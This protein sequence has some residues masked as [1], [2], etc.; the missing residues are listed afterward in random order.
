MKKQG[1]IKLI[2]NKDEDRHL[3]K[4]SG[5]ILLQENDYEITSK[6]VSVR[7]KKVLPLLI[8]SQQTVY[9]TNRCISQ[10][11]RIISDLVDVTEKFK[12]K[13]YLV[14]IDIEKAFGLLD[15]SFLIAALEKVGFGNNFVDWIKIFLND[16]ELCVIN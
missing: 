16:Q 5:P 6:V 2:E 7:L 9:V 8:S 3:T 12:T 10:Y 14:R 13:V 15:R 4:S 1:V 11:G